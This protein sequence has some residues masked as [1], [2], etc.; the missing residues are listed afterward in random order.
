MGH[1]KEVTVHI[2]KYPPAFYKLL[3]S[4]VSYRKITFG[5]S[6]CQGSP[7]DDHLAGYL[8][9]DEPE[10]VHYRLICVI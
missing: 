7:S 4:T 5:L 10:R 6:L 8:D 3:S 2:A 9:F 1:V